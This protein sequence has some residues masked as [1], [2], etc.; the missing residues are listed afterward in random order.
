[1]LTDTLY[2]NGSKYIPLQSRILV[3]K[4]KKIVVTIRFCVLY[5]EQQLIPY[6]F[7][8]HLI[9]QRIVHIT[10]VSLSLCLD[11]CVVAVTV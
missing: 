10:Q 4:S 9:K 5:Y 7:T 6:I 3:Y 2:F 8:P 11:L 1:M